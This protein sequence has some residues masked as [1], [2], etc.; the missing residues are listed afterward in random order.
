MDADVIDN[1]GTYHPV[2]AGQG[3][4]Y[5]EVRSSARDLA[6]RLNDLLP[7]SRE[8]TLAIGYLLDQVVFYANAAVARHT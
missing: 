4:I 1:Q 6:H 2:K 5:E 8:K 3:A 7:E